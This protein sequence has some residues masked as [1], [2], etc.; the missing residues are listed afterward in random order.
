MRCTV[1][2]SP[3]RPRYR[4][5]GGVDGARFALFFVVLAMPIAL[6]A[7]YLLCLVFEWGWYILGLAPLVAGAIA[8][9][10]V[11]LAVRLGRCR[12]RGLGLVAGILAGLIT[13]FSYYQFNLAGFIGFDNVHRVDLLPRWV[14]LRVLTDVQREVGRG[15]KPGD[16][17]DNDD[18]VK[19]GFRWVFFAMDLLA[20]TVPAALAGWSCAS[21]PFSERY[22]RWMTS[23]TTRVAPESADAIASSLAEGRTAGLAELALVPTSDSNTITGELKFDYLP[24]VA[25]A[26]VF[27]SV[28]HMIPQGKNRPP[29]RQV[30]LD[31]GLLTP[32]EADILGPAARLPRTGEATRSRSAAI[33]DHLSGLVSPLPEGEAG[34]VNTRGFIWRAGAL[35]LSPLLLAIAVAATFGWLAYSHWDDWDQASLIATIAVAVVIPLGLLV[36]LVRD[37]HYLPGI[38]YHKRT[39]AVLRDR[40]DALVE[41]DDPDALFVEVIPRANW[42]RLMAQNASDVGLLKVEERRRAVLFEGDRER[43]AIPAESVLSCEVE[44]FTELG[45]EQNKYNLHAVVVLVANI[46]GQPWEAPLCARITAFTPWTAD[47]RRR[48]GPRPPRPNPHDP[49]TAS[50]RSR[51]RMR[52]HDLCVVRRPG[53]HPARLDGG[54]GGWHCHTFGV[55]RHGRA[56]VPRTACAPQGGK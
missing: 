20:A 34:K 28:S 9:G 12:N 29:K 35:Q 19:T 24:D 5:S 51:E 23:Y 55:A 13:Y 48:A 44:E 6:L 27:L 31:R 4:T 38:Y 15:D 16:P 18:P 1:D 42:A 56:A 36:Y 10:G 41:A 39:M 3:E 47:A 33:G 50:A 14:Q 17:D 2:A 40:G 43:W 11:A 7:G 21:K 52:E 37:E 54:N 25:D 45:M 32:E 22:R 26:D 30:L 46:G 49:P 8:A 53:P